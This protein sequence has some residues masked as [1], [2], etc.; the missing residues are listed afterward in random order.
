[1]SLKTATHRIEGYWLS[2]TELQRFQAAAQRG[3]LVQPRAGAKGDVGLAWI[4]CCERSNEPHAVLHTGSKWAEL[5]IDPY[6][7]DWDFPP[8]VVAAVE[9]LFEIKKAEPSSVH[10]GFIRVPYLSRS[11]SEP[12]A[13]EVMRLIRTDR[14]MNPRFYPVRPWSHLRG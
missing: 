3:F 1:M 5:R 2:A 7:Y 12:I 6:C 14:E 8:T 13:H 11:K 4:S 10:G 9:A